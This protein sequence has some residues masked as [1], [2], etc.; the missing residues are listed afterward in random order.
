MSDSV[1]PHR[2]QPTRLPRPWDSPGKNTFL[3]QCMKVKSESE[4]AQSCLTLSDPMDCSPPGSSI[5]G[6]FQAR[7]LEWGAT[8]F[9]AWK[10]WGK[11]KP[12]RM[13]AETF[14]SGPALFLLLTH[15]GHTPLSCSDCPDA[16][17]SSVCSSSFLQLAC[18][19]LCIDD[20]FLLSLRYCLLHL[21]KDLHPS[22]VL[23]SCPLS[24][25]WD[26]RARGLGTV[27]PLAQYPQ[28]TV[29][30]AKAAQSVCGTAD[31]LKTIIVV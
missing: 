25:C 16:S 29:W 23:L 6:I 4:D 30:W 31:V 27:V 28:R 1:R 15:S 20:Q 21:G 13:G 11:A 12:L 10:V 22:P 5:H 9:S 18:S 19:S 26:P 7:V 24:A 2:R 3:L 17:C 14:S 8:A